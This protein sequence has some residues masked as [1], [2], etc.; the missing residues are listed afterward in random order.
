M[1]GR[2]SSVSAPRFVGPGAASIKYDFITALLTLAAQGAPLQSRLALRLSLLITA[3]FNWQTHSFAVGQRELAK[4]WGVTERTAKREL[5]ALRKANWIEV[6]VPAARNRVTRHTVNVENVLSDTMPFW[7]QVGPDFFARMS[8]TAIETDVS[9]VVPLRPID[10]NPD[11]PSVWTEVCLRLQ[12]R[13]AATFDAW[14]R[15][16]S[17]SDA[18]NGTVYL[19]APSSFVAEYISQHFFN[20]LLPS[21]KEVD[22]DV[23]DIRITVN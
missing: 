8:G 3:R 21:F 4:L 12:Q 9:N 10:R 7:N 14:F 19:T 20:V 1:I 22:Q 6:L 17:W 18:Q 23:K 15:K 5:A 2:S 11:Q 16:L 13:D